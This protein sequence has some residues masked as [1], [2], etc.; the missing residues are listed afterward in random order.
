MT[1]DGFQPMTLPP[2]W[3]MI[4]RVEIADVSLAPGM[5][6]GKAVDIIGGPANR[7]GVARAADQGVVGENSWHQPF[8]LISPWTNLQAFGGW[9]LPQTSQRSFPFGVA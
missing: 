2:F 3:A 1:V 8:G 7:G 5:A 4:I 6:V 9:K